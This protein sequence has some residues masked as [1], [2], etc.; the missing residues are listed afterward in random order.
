MMERIS[1]VS[2]R[3]A[4]AQDADVVDEDGA[5]EQCST[6]D[7][8]RVGG[9]VEPDAFAREIAKLREFERAQQGVVVGDDG[10]EEFRHHRIS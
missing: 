9:G 6:E 7:V 4:A 5:D 10:V 3:F 2:R 8:K 1:A